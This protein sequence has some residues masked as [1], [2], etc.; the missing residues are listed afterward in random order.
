LESAIE[1]I[2]DIG[3]VGCNLEDFDRRIN[4]VLPIEE[5]ADRIKRAV[6]AARSKGVPDFVINAR[7]DI[8]GEGA[9]IEDAVERGKAYLEAGATT[10]FVWGGPKGR[11]VSREEV[12]VLVKELGG[13]VNVK[14]NIGPGYLTVPELREIG[15]ARISVGPELMKVAMAAYS[16]AADELLGLS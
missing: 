2:I 1:Q 7:T 4:K 12:A 8:L 9:S 16:K 3:A 5:A 6:D 10:V 14:K 15:V 13:M 11:G